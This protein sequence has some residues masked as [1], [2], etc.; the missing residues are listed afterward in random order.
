MRIER[1]VNAELNSKIEAQQTV[2]KDDPRSS[3]DDLNKQLKAAQ[4]KY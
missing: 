3:L 4:N 2:E 1:M